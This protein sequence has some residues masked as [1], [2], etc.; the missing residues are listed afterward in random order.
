MPRGKILNFRLISTCRKCNAFRVFRKDFA[1]QYYLPMNNEKAKSELIVM[2]ILAEI[3]DINQNFKPLS[4][5]MLNID[6]AR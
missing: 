2:P 4:G 3:W 1:P 6:K 5:F